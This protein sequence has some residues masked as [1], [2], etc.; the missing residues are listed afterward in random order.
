MRFRFSLLTKT[1]QS[2]Q[3]ELA[4]EK[5]LMVRQWSASATS[6]PFS[7]FLSFGLSSQGLFQLPENQCLPTMKVISKTPLALPRSNRR[8]QGLSTPQ[9]GTK[10]SPT[11][12]KL[13]GS[14]FKVERNPPK[15]VWQIGVTSEEN[16]LVCW[17]LTCVPYWKQ[18]CHYWR[19]DFGN[20]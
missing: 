9:H 2:F 13:W 12:Y 17:F 6:S 18:G 7:L 15:E 16:R 11:I 4:N 10:N 8:R 5:L 19:I 20:N 14:N 1:F 3:L